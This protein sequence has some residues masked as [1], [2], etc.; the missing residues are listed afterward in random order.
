M[1]E[2]RKRECVCLKCKHEWTGMVA[3]GTW[4]LECP[5]CREM[6][7]IIKMETAEIRWWLYPEFKPRMYGY[8]IVS[9]GYENCLCPG[10]VEI[11]HYDDI[12]GTWYQIPPDMQVYAFAER[13]APADEPLQPPQ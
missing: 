13:P 1:S 6:E 10:V 2:W 5:E 4:L 12:K 7:G 9:I 8:Y 11:K 3:G